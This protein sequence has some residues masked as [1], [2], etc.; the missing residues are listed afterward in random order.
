[1]AKLSQDPRSSTVRA[2]AGDSLS[3]NPQ[4]SRMAWDDCGRTYNK[5]VTSVVVPI[6]N[7][8]IVSSS[9]KATDMFRIIRISHKSKQAKVPELAR[10]IT[11]IPRVSNQRTID[12]MKRLD[13][14]ISWIIYLAIIGTDLKQ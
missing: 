9:M 6:V 4:V 8:L 5:N 2:A 1:M 7:V 3:K 14:Y 10:M 13:R 12:M 11:I